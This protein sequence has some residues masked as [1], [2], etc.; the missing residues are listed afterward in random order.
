MIFYLARI[1]TPFLAPGVGRV[2]PV[3]L[4]GYALAFRKDLLLHDAHRHPL[5]ERFGQICLLKLRCGPRF[6]TRAGSAWRLLFV[7]SLFPW[8]RRY[9]VTSSVE[10]D[11]DEIIAEIELELAEEKDQARCESLQND[12]A[13][14]M[15]MKRDLQRKQ[16]AAM[17]PRKSLEEENETL[18][19]RV[20]ELE[21]RLNS[22]ERRLSI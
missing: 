17:E 2:G 13:S 7:M 10:E 1:D 5:I 19:R 21:R 9:R 16:Q 15:E 18:R 12:L 8:L 11:I 22:V 3:E 4:D 6:A 20:E 14:A